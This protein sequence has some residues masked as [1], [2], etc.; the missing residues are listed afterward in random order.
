MH[1]VPCQH[2]NVLVVGGTLEPQQRHLGVDA[3]VVL[4]SLLFGV[5][6]VSEER[7]VDGAILDIGSSDIEITLKNGQQKEALNGFFLLS[8][9]CKQL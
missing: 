5:G 7:T 4:I 1:G 3:I 6:L 2:A 8:F 9:L